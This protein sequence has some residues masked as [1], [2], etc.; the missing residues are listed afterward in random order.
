MLDVQGAVR[1]AL[2]VEDEQLLEHPVDGPVGH[3]R[4]LD[5]FVDLAGAAR[6]AALQ[7]AVAVGVEEG[8]VARRQ[9][10]RAR[11]G[12]VVDHAEQDEKLRP[13][14]VAL[15]HRVRVQ[16]SVLP[17]PRVQGGQRVGAQE[18]PILWQQ[19]PLL[20]VEQETRRSTSV[21]SP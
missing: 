3:Q 16:C 8:A 17:Q 5:A 13:G 7:E 12:A 20:G 14:A 6:A 9:R 4:R 15:V 10:H 11:A 21:S 19:V 18:R 2:A 1:N